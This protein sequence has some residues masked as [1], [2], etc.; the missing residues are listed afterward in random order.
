MFFTKIEEHFPPTFFIQWTR[1]NFF[2][3]LS[4]FF[5]HIFKTTIICTIVFS[6]SDYLYSFFQLW[7][8]NHYCQVCDHCC[9]ALGPLRYFLRYGAQQKTLGS[10][11]PLMSYLCW[12]PK[13]HHLKVSPTIWWVEFSLTYIMDKVTFLVHELLL[14]LWYDCRVVLCCLPSLIFGHISLLAPVRL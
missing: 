4:I 10:L 3:F 11:Q 9:C 13:M 2:G 1:E 5:P 12:I 7:L 8:F 6:P 14:L